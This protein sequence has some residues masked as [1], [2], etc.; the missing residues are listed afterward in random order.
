MVFLRKGFCQT[1]E[2]NLL[3]FAEMIWM[4]IFSKSD[5]LRLHKNRKIV[6]PVLDFMK[7]ELLQKFM[8]F[9]YSQK[10][11]R[12]NIPLQVGAKRDLLSLT[13][14]SLKTLHLH[15]CSYFPFRYIFFSIMQ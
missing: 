11:L 12:T 2:R 8:C 13:G 6:Y 1:N 5:C 15:S 10:D 9:I 7:H 14:L 3:K 4:E